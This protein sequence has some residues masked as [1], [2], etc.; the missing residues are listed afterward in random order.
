MP[1][2]PPYAWFEN[3]RVVN[4][5]T[6]T[7]NITQTTAE[8]SWE[9]RPG[10]AA[11]GWDFHAVMPLLTERAVA[12]IGKQNPRQ[13]FFLYFPFTS[14]H[15]PIVP[16]QQFV[17]TSRANGFGDNTIVIFSA[18]N[19]PERYAYERVRKYGR[20]SMGLLRGLKRD[21]LEGGHR[22]PFIVCWPG[23]VPAGR[24]ENGLVSQIDLFARRGDWRRLGR[25][26]VVRRG[27]RLCQ[28]HSAW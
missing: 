13:P 5:P 10:P 6:V 1:N 3:D 18:D 20:R 16:T 21:L 17:G 14:P 8:G 12:W 9:A 25:A 7:L 2:F 24:V 22:V 4:T 15:T 11:E 19:G 27:Q 23:H 28:E 26:R